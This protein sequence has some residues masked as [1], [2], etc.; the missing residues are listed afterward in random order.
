MQQFTNLEHSKE[1][2]DAIQG[3]FIFSFSLLV[4]LNVTYIIW[5]SVQNFLEKRRLKKLEAKK[6]AYESEIEL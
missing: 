4:L 1:T 3:W 2:L 5:V 6:K